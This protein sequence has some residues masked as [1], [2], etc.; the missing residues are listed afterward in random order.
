MK[1][2]KQF[3][4]ILCF[5]LISSIILPHAFSFQ[6][7]TSFP[8]AIGSSLSEELEKVQRQLDENRR[9]QTEYATLI[10][11]E[12]G[13]TQTYNT[14]I[15]IL[16]NQINLL[17]N[18]IEEKRL[19]IQELTLQ[20]EILTKDIENL[21]IEIE[22]AIDQI[23]KLENE[24]DGRLLNMYMNQ[25]EN[26]STSTTMFN[27]QGPSVLVKADT[28]RQ[29]F[30]QDTNEKLEILEGTR[31]QLDRDKIKLEEDK[32]TVSR[33]KTQVDE[34][35][36]ALDQKKVQADS[37]RK[38]YIAKLQESKDRVNQY[39]KILTVL[40]QEERDL[41]E[42]YNQ[43][44]NALLSRSE[45][46]SGIPI[47]A[48]TFIGV[49]GNTGFSYGSHLHFGV[50][51]DGVIKNPCN[52]L[53]S[54]AYGDCGGNGKLVKP[55]A[56]AVLTSGFR[57][58]SRPTHNAIDLS[59]GGAGSVVSAHDGYVYYFFESCAGAPV[60]NGGGAIAAKVC[61]SDKC[62]SGISTVYYHLKCTAE[63]KGT[64]FSCQN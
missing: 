40:P 61:E 50:S 18:Q 42:K 6:H 35:K 1:L 22:I 45:L 48:G 21:E 38:T 8:N 12:Q 16:E 43:L 33:N 10:K 64:G 62:S 58:R 25:K 32:I 3:T 51:E 47:K 29:A 39:D 27:S 5:T 20:I 15:S 52:F 13:N 19:I 46:V 11:K 57:T 2:S 14:E 53:P 36:I 17:N 56:G 26:S 4:I 41:I 55:L 37:Q 31:R 63:P 49:E 7:E 59:T 30:Q 28:Y 54:G 34:E 23:E 9:K 24:T 60:C 44:K